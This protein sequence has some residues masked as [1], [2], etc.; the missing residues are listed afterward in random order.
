MPKVKAYTENGVEFWK[1]QVFIWHLVI[2]PAYTKF[3]WCNAS[4][5]VFNIVELVKLFSHTLLFHLKTLRR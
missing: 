1:F 4:L 3:I 5:N 2:S